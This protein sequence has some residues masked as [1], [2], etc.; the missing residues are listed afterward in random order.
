MCFEMFFVLII[1]R[2]GDWAQRK[3]EF[4]HTPRA[5]EPGQ[6]RRRAEDIP[7]YLTVASQ[8]PVVHTH[9]A[10]PQPQ[11]LHWCQQNQ[12]QLP[13]ACAEHRHS[14]ALGSH[15]NRERQNTAYSDCSSTLSLS[16]SLRSVSSPQLQQQGVLLHPS[17]QLRSWLRCWA[18]H[19]H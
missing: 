13:D 5:L 17:L 18:A 16:C 11:G 6:C 1:F 2:C 4:P 3:Q 7:G 8:E 19:Q 14:A 12:S 15:R 9:A 10:L